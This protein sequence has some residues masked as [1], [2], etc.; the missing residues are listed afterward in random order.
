MAIRT[1]IPVDR[2]RHMFFAYPTFHRDVE[3]ALADLGHG[4]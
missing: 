3:D 1:E 4:N 2:L